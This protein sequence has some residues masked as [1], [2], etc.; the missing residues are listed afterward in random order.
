MRKLLSLF[1]ALLFVL[2]IGGCKQADWLLVP[3]G[4]KE[5]L[6]E[7]E[8][9]KKELDAAKLA[10]AEAKTDE[11]KAAAQAA[12]IEATA[13]AEKAAKAIDE[14]LESGEPSRLY[15][16]ASSLGILPAWVIALLGLGGATYTGVRAK[17]KDKIIK[18]VATGV[19][20][21][22]KTDEAEKVKDKIGEKV[23]DAGVGPL[24]DA[25]LRE[26]GFLKKSKREAA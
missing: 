21:L 20:A 11:E 12:L 6:D 2:G 3:P 9:A 1:V 14:A 5:A 22:G 17:R 18:A 15:S 24:F 26:L 10:L 7:G 4:T 23:E 25:V 16:F 8:K 13:N 19:E